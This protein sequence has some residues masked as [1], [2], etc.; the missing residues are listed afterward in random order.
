MTRINVID[1]YL[2]LDQFLMAEYREL[3]MVIASAR[4]SL[5]ASKQ[6]ILA[7]GPYTLN[8][9]HVTFFY[10]KAGWLQ[11]RYKILIDELLSRGFNLDPEARGV[12]FAP[13]YEF[14]QVEDWRPTDSDREVNL[15]RLRLRY[16]AKPTWY[17]W[18]RGKPTDAIVSVYN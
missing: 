15:A 10:N 13:M 7:T 2:L 17:K 12:D 18:C 4:R 8:K 5:R 11:E 14:P 16:A 9:G 6:P 1:P 3:P